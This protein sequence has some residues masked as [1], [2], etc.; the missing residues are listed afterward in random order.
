MQFY[1][2][3]YKKLASYEQIKQIGDKFDVLDANKDTALN[4]DEMANIFAGQTLTQEEKNM[5]MAGIDSDDD[6]FITYSEFIPTFVEFDVDQNGQISGEEFNLA[7][8]RIDE[9]QKQMDINT[10]Y[11]ILNNLSSTP[12]QKTAAQNQISL[13]KVQRNIIY[14]EQ[15]VMQ[16]EI[17]ISSNELKIQQIQDYI[18]QNTLLEFEQAQK[19]KEIETCNLAKSVLLLEKDIVV[20]ELNLENVNLSIITTQQ[21]GGTQNALDILAQQKISKENELNISLKNLELYQ[22]QAK[23]QNDE[24]LITKFFIP[25]VMKENA[26]I[27]LDILYDEVQLLNQRKD[28]YSKVSTLSQT[29]AQMMIVW[30]QYL[31]AQT[32]AEKEILLQQ[33][34]DLN[35]QQ[36]VQQKEAQISA[37]KVEL[38]DKQIQ[39]KAVLPR[40][41]Q[42]PFDQVKAKLEAEIANL[43]SQIAAL[44]PVSPWPIFPPDNPDGLIY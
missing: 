12:A 35:A 7:K 44:E 10:Q 19:L 34:N 25:E 37:L 18:S 24:S 1:S 5:F 33:Y 41:T 40:S 15:K 17:L 27:E 2:T 43:K 16:K 23:I 30:N 28:L 42:K 11:A 20:K 38:I 22:K 21:Q 32:E 6:G 4:K 36:L 31:Q 3:Y 26:R 13:F 29:R 39:L 8:K 14:A 9:L